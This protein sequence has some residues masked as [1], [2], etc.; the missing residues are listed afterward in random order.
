LKR[1]LVRRQAVLWLA[2]GNRADSGEALDKK[3]LP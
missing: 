2:A 3:A 1:S